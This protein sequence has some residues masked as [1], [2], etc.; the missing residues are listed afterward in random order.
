MP[1]LTSLNGPFQLSEYLS[2]MVKHDPHDVKALVEIPKTE[3]GSG[4]AP[5][6]N[7]VSCALTRW[8]TLI[9]SGYTSISGKLSSA[10]L[11]GAVTQRGDTADAKTTAYRLDAAA[12]F[13]LDDMLARLLSGNEGRS[14]ALH[15]CSASEH[16]RVLRYRLHPAHVSRLGLKGGF[17][18]D[19]QSGLHHRFAQFDAD[20]P[21]E[22]SL[23]PRLLGHTN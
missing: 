20:F 10:T 14:M 7:V 12:D 2:L 9:A 6:R 3:G 8:T 5:E 22:V 15:L 21:I 1:D 19:I 11:R 23:R 4:K 13:A 18:A 17:G 16:R